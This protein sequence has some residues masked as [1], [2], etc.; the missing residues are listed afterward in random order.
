M[1]LRVL[2]VHSGNLYGGIETVLATLV[3]ERA[4]ASLAHHF[5]L[6]FGGRL[7]DELTGLDSRVHLLGSV[8]LSMPDSVRRARI[9][10]R[11]VL[12]EVNPDVVVTHLP[13]THAVFGGTLKSA[14]RPVVQWVHGPLGGL[15]GALARLALPD[16]IICNSAHTRTRLPSAY[17]RLPS[18]VIFNPL[19]V[20]RPCDGAARAA[21]RASMGAAPG[22][23]VIVQASRLEAWKGHREHL[24]ALGRLSAVPNWVLWIVGGAQRPREAAYLRELHDLARSLGIVRRVRF[25][26]EQDDVWRFL[27]SADLYCQPNIGPEP[28]G[29][30]YVEA[31]S[32]GLPV[33]ASDSGALPEIVDARTGVLVPPRDVARLAAALRGLIED[34]PMRRRLAG[35]ARDRARVLC[36]APRQ[37][38]RVATFIGTLACGS[39]A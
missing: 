1:S 31:M 36:E 14:G 13:W 30:T 10:L 26:G 24:R 11:G 4:S 27:A 9:A 28:F 29:M 6:C 21:A 34:E 37:I 15:V 5:A 2:H 32:S 33:V 38:Q 23:V 12:T 35:A 25:A 22:D 3:R 16:A 19:T 8:R 39:G 18:E 20:P 7:A 17:R